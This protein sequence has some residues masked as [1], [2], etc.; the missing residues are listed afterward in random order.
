M[1][2]TPTLGWDAIKG[3]LGG[4]VEKGQR[5][6]RA[7]GNDYN[8]KPPAALLLYG[9]PG[10]G[11]ST[12]GEVIASQLGDKI[13][14]F[15]VPKNTIQ[16][17]PQLGALFA[18]AAERAPSVILFD[19]VNGFMTKQH[20]AMVPVI[21]NSWKVGNPTGVQQ[22]PLP[23]VLVIGTTNYPERL[24]GAVLNRFGHD[25][26]QK[27]SIEVG[28]PDD[29]ARKAIFEDH[30]KD[31]KHNLTEEDFNTLIALMPGSVG[32]DIAFLVDDVA[33]EV[34]DD[35]KNPVHARV[36]E[37]ISLADF[38]Q[39]F[40]TEE[41]ESTMAP[42]SSH[43]FCN[44]ARMLLVENKS[45]GTQSEE[46]VISVKYM[47]EKMLSDANLELLGALNTTKLRKFPNYLSQ[48][49]KEKD[50]LNNLLTCLQKI[51][52]SCTL[53]F[54]NVQHEKTFLACNPS[55]MHEATPH[56]KLRQVYPNPFKA[57]SKVW[58]FTHLSYRPPPAW[59]K[60]VQAPT[61]WIPG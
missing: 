27:R 20:T 19:E 18:I 48:N 8:R 25:T 31:I 24:D 38:Q 52:P 39:Q 53:L 49:T 45:P 44:H 56:M 22:K 17:A 7:I 50:F 61:F 42:E 34:E 3:D 12:L 43:Q 55:F 1:I 36:D 47:I 28:P 60:C 40:K 57:H 35:F 10:T 51:S 4:A 15:D 46:Q 54:N 14:F 33:S 11:K 37:Y 26:M 16:T 41:A 2:K 58:Y 13:T 59:I 30:L 9:P 29:A 23:Y 21:T 5:Y 6:V 32:R